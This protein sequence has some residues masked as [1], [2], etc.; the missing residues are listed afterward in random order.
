[1]GVPFEGASAILA[2]RTAGKRPEVDAVSIF[3]KYLAEIDSLV[4]FVNG[5]DR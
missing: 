2:I 5:L 4:R 3:D 1:M